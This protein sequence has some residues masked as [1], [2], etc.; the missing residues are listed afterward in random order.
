MPPNADHEVQLGPTPFWGPTQNCLSHRFLATHSLTRMPPGR[1]QPFAH[2]RGRAQDRGQETKGA[3][4]N[5]TQTQDNWDVIRTIMPPT[6]ATSQPPV[7]V[8]PPWSALGLRTAAHLPA[9]SGDA[10]TACPTNGCARRFASSGRRTRAPR[11]RLGKR[12]LL[13]HGLGRELRAF[14]LQACVLTHAV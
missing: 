4:Q 7:P 1:T 6:N 14:L 11:R 12:G 9:H 10:P 5:E 2:T 8:L 13:L 3:I